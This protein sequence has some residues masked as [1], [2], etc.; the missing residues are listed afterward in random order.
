VQIFAGSSAVN[1]T[2]LNMG[3]AI[4]TIPANGQAMFH[5]TDTIQVT[6]GLYVTGPLCAL[7]TDQA[8]TIAGG[9]VAQVFPIFPA[10]TPTTTPTAP[11]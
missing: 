10:Q 11:R 9:V 4:S 3:Y 6:E 5:W 7:N 1:V 2:F 8:V